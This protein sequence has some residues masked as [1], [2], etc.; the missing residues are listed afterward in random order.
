MTQI[1]WMW[2]CTQGQNDALRILDYT[3]SLHGDCISVIFSSLCPSLAGPE[4]GSTAAWDQG[5]FTDAR[6]KH[7]A[8]TV[9]ATSK[10]QSYDLSLVWTD[11]DNHWLH[12]QIVLFCSDLIILAFLVPSSGWWCE[13]HPWINIS[14]VVAHLSWWWP[15]IQ[16][17]FISTEI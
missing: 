1:I 10:N 7:P 11:A 9:P 16:C 4:R 5:M 12:R 2:K 15:F 8:F 14:A 6:S 17:D 13:I 3:Q